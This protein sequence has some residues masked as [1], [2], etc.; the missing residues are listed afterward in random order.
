MSIATFTLIFAF[1]GFL[2]PSRRG[3]LIMALLVFYVLMGSVAGYVTA[4]FY[5]SFN[6]KNFQRAT[7]ATAFGFP[8]MFF[9]IFFVMNLIAVAKGSGDA[10][11]FLRMVELLVIWFGVST[12]LVFAGAFFGYKVD[13]FEYPVSVSTLP[14]Q[15]PDQPWYMKPILTLF[16]GGILSFGACFLE[17]YFILSSIWMDQYYYIF[18]F[19]SLTFLILIV[20]VAESTVLLNYIQLCYEDYHWWWRSFMNA[21]SIAIFVYGYAIMYFKQLETNSVATYFLYFGYMGL[22]CFA[23]FLLTGSLGV[24]SCLWFNKKIF[25]AIKID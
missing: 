21:G 5:K 14:R 1:M 3:S 18:G 20:T 15:I 6:G 2:N 23:F 9:S 17:L 10:V 4:R 8:S 22:M 13:A 24:L 12:P 11:P 25:G 7:F 19:L 16:F